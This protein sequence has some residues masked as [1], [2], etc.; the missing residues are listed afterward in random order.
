MHRPAL[1]LLRRPRDVSQA[2][3]GVFLVAYLAGVVL[4]LSIGL[5]PSLADWIAPL[6]RFLED[7]AQ[8]GGPLST[9]AGRV[10]DA[11]M[12]LPGTREVVV[13][14]LFSALNL[15]LGLLLLLTRRRQL[16]PV[17]LAVA[18]LGTAA[19]FNEPSH[20]V[21]HVTGEPGGVK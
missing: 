9:F 11:D 7:L 5:L 13:Q 17:L 4:W 16:V 3:L 14:Y 19:T 6:H 10:V 8:G 20:A 15:A 12:P 1:A 21:F 2:A 18:L